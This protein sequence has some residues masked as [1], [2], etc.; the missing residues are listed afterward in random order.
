VKTRRSSN[1][2]ARCLNAL[3]KWLRD[4]WLDRLAVVDW[5]RGFH[6]WLFESNTSS[7]SKRRAP[8]LEIV[9]L[10]TREVPNDIFG[11]I[12]GPF[13]VSGM[14]LLQGN[15]QTPASVVARGWSG[16][17]PSGL[18]VPVA[19]PVPGSGGHPFVYDPPADTVGHFPHVPTTPVEFGTR[20]ASP[21]PTTEPVNI[22]GPVSLAGLPRTADDW[23]RNPLDEDSPSSSRQG[24]T[25][26]GGGNS[27]G[28][29]AGF[30]Q[31]PSAPETGGMN[32]ELP[33]P[34]M[35]PAGSGLD[36][37]LLGL[38][39]PDGGVG[40][41]QQGQVVVGAA[42]GA[43]DGA[44]PPGA[45]APGAPGSSLS[46][47]P[48]GAA[49]PLSSAGTAAPTPKTSPP[50]NLAKNY[51]QSALAYEL[52][53][54]QTDSQVRFLSHGPG[55]GL[56]LT[57]AFAEFAVARPNQSPTRDVFRM[58]FAGANANASPQVFAENELTSRA[59]YL[60]GNDPSKYH[61]D[62]PEY[63]QVRYKNLYPGVDLVYHS[64]AGRQL[65]YD[66][67]VAPGASVANIH[68]GWQGVQGLS[69]DAQGNLVLQ[70][71]GGRVVQQAPAMYQMVNG[72]RQTVTGRHVL[73]D[74]QTVGFQA[75]AYDATKPLIIDPVVSFATYLG[76]SGA[77]YAYGVAVG[78][79]GSSYLTGSTASADFPQATG[80]FTG[81]ADGFVSKLDPTGQNLV[82]S[83]YVG[84]AGTTTGT[85]SNGIAIDQAG[86][87][88]IT[89]T[90]DSLL[91][92]TTG[93]AVQPTPHGGMSTHT[94]AFVAALNATGDDLLYGTYLGGSS[95]T[96]DT[97]NA[98][99]VDINGLAYVAG[100]TGDSG[101]PTTPLA[102]QSSFPLGAPNTVAFVSVLNPGTSSLF[103]FSDV[104]TTYLG[105]TVGGSQTTTGQG[106]AV[107][108]QGQV[109]V[110][111]ST[112]APGFPT[113]PGVV[114]M[115]I[116]ASATANAFVT[117]LNPAPSTPL[118][119]STFLGGSGNDAGNAIVVDTSGNAY[120]A[121]STTSGNFPVHNAFQSLNA[122]SQN[123]FVSELNATA[124][125]LPYSSYL[126]GAG[127]T[128]GYAI[129]LDR[130][131]T[132]YLTGST[133]SGSTFPTLNAFQSGAFGGTTYAY[134]TSVF[135]GGFRAYSSLLGGDSTLVGTMT[136]AADNVG[137]GVGVD[138]SGNVY[139]DGYTNSTNF[140][141]VNPFQG[142][143]NTGTYDAFLAKVGLLP[144]VPTIVTAVLC[145]LA[146]S[147]F[148]SIPISQPTTFQN[149]KIQ[150]TAPAS[151]TLLLYQAG[152]GV[153]G[154][155][156]ANGSGQWTYDYSG[157]TL[158]EGTYDFTATDTVNGATSPL[159]AD[160]LATIDETAP[161][162]GLVVPGG[163]VTAPVQTASLLPQLRVTAS[164]LNGLPN[165]TPV[166]LDV[167][168][169]P[170]G[171]PVGTY[172]NAGVLTDGVAS[173]RVPTTLTVN[174]TYTLKAQVTDR[175][176]NVGTSSGVN[177]QITTVSNP[178]VPTAQQV[179]SDP[180]DGQSGLQLGNVHVEHALDLDQSPGTVQ[181]G[182][183][184]FVYNSDSVSVRPV[185][186]AVLPSNNNAALP[187]TISGTL[188]WD[189]TGANAASTFSYST[190]G[191]YQGD[192]LIVA[193]QVPSAGSATGRYL[194]RLD[195]ST[196]AGR[197]TVTGAAFVVAQDASPFGAGW[198]LST[199][200]RLIDIAAQ[201]AFPAGKLR[202]YGTGESR[203][204]ASNG[205]GGYTSPAND[206]GTLTVATVGITTTYTYTSIDQQTWTF[207]G[208]GYQTRWASE[209]GN[210]TLLYRYDGSNR[211]MGATAID[212]APATFAYGTY[213]LLQT[214]QAVN[215]QTTT[216]AY[217]G[218]ALTQITNPDGGL[219][220]LSYDG[221]KHLTGETWTSTANPTVVL[222]QN[223]WFY[224]TSGALASYTW[225]SLQSSSGD[226]NPSNYTLSPAIVQGLGGLVAG[227]VMATSTEP[228]LQPGVAAHQSAFQLDGA[229]RLLQALAADGGLTQDARDA[230]GRVTVMTDPLGRVTTY[231]RDSAGYVTQITNPDGTTRNYQYQASDH[232]LT[233]YTDERGNTTTYQYDGQGHRKTA[234]DALGR[235]TTFTY[236][237]GGA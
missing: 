182:N 197:Q 65:E 122:G 194:W 191:F 210:Q 46:L 176:G 91:F 188:T 12:Q 101:F 184:A 30:G 117:K 74:S 50:P 13:V 200:D 5:L 174:N 38:L 84:G 162:V 66:F 26:P 109:Y 203:F 87:A 48:F 228:V 193:A 139:V 140:P 85:V 208:N 57:G 106:I 138:P 73:I 77:D 179:A 192:V 149:L 75:D 100:T 187:G 62:V 168:N 229:G 110:T 64:A 89:G 115:N 23:L 153:L 56:F 42:G 128:T 61:A 152:K 178:W 136:V 2:L 158:A 129:A 35:E 183:P 36:P 219:H 114:Q 211:L 71:A 221:N 76:G 45:A 25:G 155:T 31:A 205:M 121:G 201:G 207:N 209:D 41:A 130:Q 118:V 159:S 27:L 125:T 160:A 112:T 222:L 86:N 120:V 94:A 119:Y 163:T 18:G 134:L 185:I 177:V 3:R 175:A 204:Y 8:G 9:P 98:I 224:G 137:R 83:T 11:L 170:S 169:Y 199:V 43:A 220:T 19:L 234:T 95:G 1:P 127:S 16:G 147:Q 126:G 218:T 103:L 135:S 132:V 97:G 51:G 72:T 82:Y 164:D 21:A 63:G 226:T 99:A 123:A 217:S 171:T 196:P 237:S 166:T 92:P 102:Y 53:V 161:A 124:T 150:G 90:T 165:G 80:T 143:L 227:L 212:G 104:Y 55:F 10:E 233:T 24:H 146:G 47:S 154:S 190:T 235:V 32:A 156:T 15:L 230:N 173:F 189:T 4:S 215:G 33:A 206:A 34:P 58:Q 14:A 67:E 133:T 59:N 145:N 214:I 22:P 216:L 157:T 113:T 20:T 231:A 54:G 141:T 131:R 236:Y 69:L 39:G 151:A 105:A 68:L 180:L 52:N 142:V 88:Y 29:G 49:T 186:Q 213:T 40:A 79:D 78:A 181:S 195:V 116:G 6:E 172:T 93:N 60:I 81:P 107:D 17:L 202:V 28:S 232:A 108:T 37:A 148:G 223:E 225:G 198:T 70:T 144:A 96:T 44:Q 111:G 7:R 167:Y